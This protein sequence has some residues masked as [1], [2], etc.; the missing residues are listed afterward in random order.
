MNRTI[1]QKS[2]PRPRHSHLH[3]YHKIY[4]QDLLSFSFLSTGL[5]SLLLILL[6]SQYLSDTDLKKSI[7]FLT[8]FITTSA[9]SSWKDT[10]YFNSRSSRF[11]GGPYLFAVLFHI[12]VRY[13]LDSAIQAAQIYFFHLKLHSIYY[14]FIICL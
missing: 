9:I 13:I 6:T 11:E 3:L 7:S 4:L 12:L 8:C 10:W 2:N 14:H 5:M 1:L